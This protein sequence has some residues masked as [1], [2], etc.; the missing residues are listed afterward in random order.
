M[1]HIKNFRTEKREE[2]VKLERENKNYM[3]LTRKTL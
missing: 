2:I 1:A 3:V